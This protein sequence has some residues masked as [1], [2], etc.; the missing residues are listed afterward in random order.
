ML[1]PGSR[2]RMADDLLETYL[3][4]LLE[5]HPGPEVAVAWQDGEPNMMGAD[6]RSGRRNPDAACLDTGCAAPGLSQPAC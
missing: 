3:R 4:Q 6:L 1:Y 2:F 5:S